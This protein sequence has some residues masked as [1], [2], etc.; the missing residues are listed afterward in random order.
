MTTISYRKGNWITD[1][2]LVDDFIKRL[3][4]C[5]KSGYMD[6]NEDAFQFFASVKEKRMYSSNEMHMLEALEYDIKRNSGEE[7]DLPF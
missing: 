7:H 6:D 2:A 4:T 3:D 5:L 1:A